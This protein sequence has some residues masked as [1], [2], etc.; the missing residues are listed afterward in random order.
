MIIDGKD[1]AI[2]IVILCMEPEVDLTLMAVETLLEN[3]EDSVVISVLMNGG[4]SEKMKR[5]FSAHE[6]LR[7]YESEENLGVAGGRNF[8]FRTEECR[9]SD[10]IMIL[11]NDVV[12]PQDYVRNL[13]TFLLEQEDA[14]IVGPAIA[15][16]TRACTDGESLFQYCSTGKLKGTIIKLS[17]Q[18]IKA[19][20]LKDFDPERLYHVGVH[21]NY[22]FAYFSILPELYKLESYLLRLFGIKKSW[23]PSLRLNTKYLNLI[24]NGIDKY[25]VSNVGGGSQVFRR[26]LLDEIGGLDERF[27]QYGLEDAHFSIRALQSGY[28]NYID[29]NTWLY[30]GTNRKHATRNMRDMFANEYEKRTIL[31]S[32]VLPKSIRSRLAPTKVAITAFFTTFAVLNILIA[33]DLFKFLFVDFTKHIIRANRDNVT[34][35]LAKLRGARKG[36]QTTRGRNAD[37]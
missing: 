6:S 24:R 32:L 30:H 22:Y 9:N 25:A 5:L 34:V 28:R 26:T 1:W 33:R 35:A 27:N 12:P 36:L 21:E 37:G 3:L 13:A 8:L 29:A 2:N 16:I 15:D 10:I 17:S 31:A 20:T 23:H 14:G 19:A 11:D 7:Y 18:E 4:H